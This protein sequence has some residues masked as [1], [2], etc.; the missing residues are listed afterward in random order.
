M[1]EMLY[2]V[3][4]QD[5]SGSFDLAAEML[6]ALELDFSSWEDRENRRGLHTVYALDPD[7]ARNN[8]DRIRQAVADWTPLGLE[9]GD[10]EYFEMKKEDWS[11]VWK[12]YFHLLPISG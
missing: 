11:E 10:I 2:C 9:V 4:L 8:L 12:K 1:D 7:T 3:K 5:N 6:A